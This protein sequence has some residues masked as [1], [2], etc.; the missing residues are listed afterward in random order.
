MEW[1][2]E[3]EAKMKLTKARYDT[4]MLNNALHASVVRTLNR[5]CKTDGIT[6]GADIAAYKAEYLDQLNEVLVVLLRRVVVERG[7]AKVAKQRRFALLR[8]SALMLTA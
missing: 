5:E 8:K 3:I 1:S 6:D 7:R 4:V 2:N